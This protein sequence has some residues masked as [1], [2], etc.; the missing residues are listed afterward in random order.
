VITVDDIIKLDEWAARG[1]DEA[2][3]KRRGEEMRQ[4]IFPDGLDEEEIKE[5]EQVVARARAAKR[6][7]ELDDALDPMPTLAVP[8]V[9]V[10]LPSKWEGL[11]SKN[12][13]MY[14]RG[15]KHD[16]TLDEVKALRRESRGSPFD[17]DSE[18][19]KKG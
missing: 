7:K 18:P 10:A 16:G 2:E 5:R 9:P 14:R 12:S 11:I 6:Q 15:S 19:M 8:L 1:K 17:V 13:K 4:Q 3:R